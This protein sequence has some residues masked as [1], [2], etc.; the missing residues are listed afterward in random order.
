[1]Y[2]R[3]FQK[4]ELPLRLVAPRLLTLQVQ[5]GRAYKLFPPW[6]LTYS[7]AIA[8]TLTWLK[9]VNN[10]SCVWNLP[11]PFESLL[12]LSFTMWQ[13]E[14][15]DFAAVSSAGGSGALHFRRSV[16][17]EQARPGAKIRRKRRIGRMSWCGEGGNCRKWQYRATWKISNHDW[18]LEGGGLQAAQGNLGTYQVCI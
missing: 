16:E 2:L 14:G 3:A 17:S 18:A 4:L 11:Q 1:M 10:D 13:L 8:V 15:L 5:D 7:V 6:G 12:G 9:T